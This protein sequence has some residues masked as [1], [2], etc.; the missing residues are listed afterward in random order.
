MYRTR[1]KKNENTKL[2]MGGK[3]R[4]KV[5]VSDTTENL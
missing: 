2:L 1:E 4:V 3:P 5:R